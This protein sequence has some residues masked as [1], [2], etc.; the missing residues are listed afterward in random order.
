[1]AEAAADTVSSEIGQAIGGV[2]CLITNWKPAAAGTDG[3]LT[4]AGTAAGIGAAIAV[5]LT[6]IVPW[7]FA[8]I[9]A[10]SGIL[11]MFA[12]SLLGATLERRRFMDNNAVNFSSTAIAALIAFQIA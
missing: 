9:C 2:P 6:G 3:A 1:M 11:G 4:F 10:A 7:P 12:D 5:S 8:P